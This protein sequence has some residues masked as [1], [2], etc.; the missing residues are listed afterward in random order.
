MTDLFERPSADQSGRSRSAM[1]ERRAAKKRKKRRQRNS[2]IVAVA[3]LA[4]VVGGYF[5][6]RNADS[7]FGGFAVPFQTKD[8]EGPGHG[9][10]TIT[11]P[12]GA[13]GTEIGQI[14]VD[15]DVVQSVKA[16]VNAYN[17]NPGAVGIQPGSY[18]LM[19]EMKASD[20]VA[21]L[22]ANEA[23]DDTKLTVPEGFT[24]AQIT[25]RASAITGIPAANFEAALA[26]PDSFGLPVE[27]GGHAE[28]WFF[29]TTYVLDPDETAQTLLAKMVQRT[30]LEL[31]QLGVAT[32]QR[33]AVLNKAS[34]VQKEAP[35]GQF[36]KVARVIQNRIDRGDTLGMDAIDAYGLGKPSDQITTEE[37]KDPANPFASRVHPGLPPTPIANP[38]LDAINAVLQPADGPWLWYVTVNLDTGETKFTDDYQEF[39]QF[40]KEY[41]AWLDANPRESPTDSVTN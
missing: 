20:A 24:V 16:F 26:A 10:V 25:A 22:V 35:A 21:A 6:V 14:L 37:F 39:L 17:A 8:Y 3:L 11:V 28:G 19:L 13:T 9:S 29:P 12:E 32:D 18:V 7:L 27:A 30:T 34:I 2:A 36:D 40:K 33:E 41:K 38:G 23:I 4:I 31:D 15:N 5:G 1:R